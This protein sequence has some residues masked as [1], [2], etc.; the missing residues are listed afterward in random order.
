M[1]PDFILASGIIGQLALY[2]VFPALPR[3]YAGMNGL[4]P[5]L[6]K[7]VVLCLVLWQEEVTF[8]LTLREP[9]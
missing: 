2:C 6:N 9:L 7:Q 5:W 1:Q 4:K 8:Q 3:K